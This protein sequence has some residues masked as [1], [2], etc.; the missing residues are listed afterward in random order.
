MTVTESSQVGEARRLSIALGRAIGLDEVANGEVAIVAT[1]LANNL[2]RHATGGELIVRSFQECDGSSAKT[3][4]LELLAIDRGPGFLNFSSAMQ[5]G[6]STGGT[7]G[8]GLGAVWRLAKDMDVYTQPGRGTAIVA[9]F[10]A[11][12]DEPCGMTAS[13][14]LS[15]GAISLPLAGEELCGDSW[16]A[17]VDADGRAVILV[18]DGLGHGPQ[19]AR[20]SQAAV[21]C[22]H[23]NRQS[24]TNRIVERIHAALRGTRGSAIA[25]AEIAASGSEMRFTGVGNISASIVSATSTRSMVSQPGT[26]GAEARRI[27]EYVYPMSPDST[28]LMHSDGLAGHGQISHYPGLHAKHPSLIAA[29]LYR[30]QRRVRDDAT[31]LIVRQNRDTKRELPQ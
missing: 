4:G 20:A 12:G 7:A 22:F 18:A 30:D 26:A 17:A 13:R 1:E 10:W 15:F 25:V 3:R 24:P 31:V 19:A 16:A 8:T 28:L 14:P 6:Y 21:Q 23:E 2:A 11:G 9:R 29:V 27:H 5:D